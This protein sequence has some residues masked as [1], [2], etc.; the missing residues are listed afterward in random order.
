MQ[1][2][3]PAVQRHQW[4]A[5]PKDIQV[6]ATVVVAARFQDGVAHVV[7]VERKIKARHFSAQIRASSIGVCGS[8]ILTSGNAV[9]GPLRLPHRCPV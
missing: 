3:A 1:S 2:A 7:L 4:E 9:F 5:D 6:G 8:A